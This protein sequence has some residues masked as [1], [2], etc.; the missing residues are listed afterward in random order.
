M[1]LWIDVY[2]PTYTTL[3][4]DGPI[5]VVSAKAGRALDG[6][7]RCS[8]VV[9]ATDARALSLLSS[10]RI[11]EVWYSSPT[12]ANGKRLLCA[13][14]IHNISFAD[15]A[16]RTM[17]INGDDAL[18]LLIT[19]IT[20]LRDTYSQ[21]SFSTI[22]NTL[23]NITGAGWDFDITNTL[24]ASKD[25]S[26]RFDGQT[27]LKALQTLCEHEG[28]HFRLKAGE[29][30][31]VEIGFF[32]AQTSVRVEAYEGAPHTISNNAELSLL[33]RISITEKSQDIVNAILPTG[34]SN[35]EFYIDLEESTRGRKVTTIRNGVTEYWL[36][37][38]PSIATYGR[39][40]RRMTFREIAPVTNS[41]AD[42]LAASNVLDDAAYAELNWRSLPQTIYRLEAKKVDTTI[43]VGD[44]LPV[45]YRGTV[46]QDGTVTA[47]RTIDGTFWVLSADEN[48]GD[49]GQTVALE[50]S[51]ID[52]QSTGV[53]SVVLGTVDAIEVNGVN[54][55]P[56]AS[57]CIFGPY[58]EDIDSSTSATVPIDLTSSTLR[59][60]R[61]YLRFTTSPFRSNVVGAASG[62]GSTQTSESGGGST[63][64]SVAGGDHHHILAAEVIGAPPPLSTRYWVLK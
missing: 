3:Q 50:V 40:E 17:Q 27:V 37:D 44:R 25:I 7:A 35:G 53:A 8:A 61:V 26:T 9:P 31:T 32:G 45:A 11:A 21:Q 12:D 10:R 24:L 6:P 18:S 57:K 20:Y 4:G 1:R 56:E 29:V 47:T 23:E 39:I 38:A 30:R 14:V 48:V 41:A 16:Q 28:A 51:N 43:S 46:L 33:K 2:D 58:Y 19:K 22:V 34:A 59:I 42:R 52:R 55:Q 15:D 54:V 62:G 63:Q 36:E 5:P 13:F 64:T 49:D 60:V